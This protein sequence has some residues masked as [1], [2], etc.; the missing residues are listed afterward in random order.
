MK[1]EKGKYMKKLYELSEERATELFKYPETFYGL[2]F[3][4]TLSTFKYIL[5]LICFYLFFGLFVFTVPTICLWA[6]LWRF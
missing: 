2:I 1:L 5:G 3:D 4:E 6:A